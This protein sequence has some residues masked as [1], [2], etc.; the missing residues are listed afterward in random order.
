MVVRKTVGHSTEDIRISLHCFVTHVPV[1]FR[2]KSVS[3]KLYWHSEV[4]RTRVWT[5]LSFK[6]PLPHANE[7]FNYNKKAVIGAQT[8]GVRDVP[9]SISDDD[10]PSALIR[11]MVDRNNA[12]EMRVGPIVSAF[13]AWTIW[14]ALIK[15]ARHQCKCVVRWNPLLFLVMRS[16]CTTEHCRTKSHN[17]KTVCM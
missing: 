4:P 17:N 6:S 7:P 16:F 2:V 11:L 12:C 9:E 5:I 1:W 14:F 10:S 13:S 15:D 3:M 8:G